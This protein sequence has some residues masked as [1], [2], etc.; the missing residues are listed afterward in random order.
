MD[1]IG[2][3]CMPTG[4]RDGKDI[5]GSGGIPYTQFSNVETNELH[6]PMLYLHRRLGK[7]AWGHGY[8]RGG[9]SIELT[10]KPHKT[11]MIYMLLWNHGA[12]FSNGAGISGGLGPSAV[13]FKVAR[14]TDIDEKFQAGDVPESID[15]FPTEVLRAKSE[16]LLGCDDLVFFGVPG[17][18]GYGDPIKREPERV[19]AD[20]AAGI[21]SPEHAARFYGVVCKGEEPEVDINATEAERAR[22][23]ETRLT[24]GRYLE[25]WEKLAPPERETPSSKEVSREQQSPLGPLRDLFAVGMGLKVVRDSENKHWW[26]CSDCGHVYC[27]AAECPKRNALVRIGYLS[28]MSHPTAE[29]ARRDPPRFFHR[30][31]YCPECALQFTTEMARADDPIIADIVYDPAWLAK[32]E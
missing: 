32:W 14:N 11:G 4:I 24:Y 9:R 21:L 28:E 17:A 19:L 6:Y 29:M 10:F 8:H 30:Q 2:M 13:R 27:I 15:E 18:G 12:E 23:R 22:I 1:V 16:N 5:T 20:V 31:F 26:A 25:D 3:C 7:D